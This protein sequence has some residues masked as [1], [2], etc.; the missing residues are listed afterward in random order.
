MGTTRLADTINSAQA[1]Q[2]SVRPESYARRRAL[3]WMLPALLIVVVLFGGGLVLGVLQ[4]L[5]YFPGGD[6][7]FTFN[8]VIQVFSDPDFFTSL[9]L[10]F[11]MAFTSTLI[12]T[13]LSVLCALLLTNLTQRFQWLY[14][15]LQI[16]LVVPH[17]VIAIAL[18][19]LLAPTG[20]LARVAQVFH[21]IA[22][23]EQFPLLVHDP[24]LVGVILVYV[25]KE[26][27]FITL[28]ILSVLLN[29]GPDF[30]DVGKTLKATSWQRFRFIIL[31]TIAP[32]L[33]AGALIVFAYS[34]GTF[35][36]PYLLGQTFP[37]TLPVWA[38]RNYSD[39]DLLSRPE[40]IAMGIIIAI[41]IALCVYGAHLLL[42]KPS[43]RTLPI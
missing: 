9:V 13:V 26:V 34:F 2:T 19:F 30:L 32:N 14:T 36:V 23:A 39:I 24:W 7:T 38:Y 4:A 37:M 35:E 16:P 27:P 10:T 6:A 15:I 42:R 8:H 20:F 40:G 25:W 1:I 3:L 28:M 12:A 5:G 41:I 43:S 31:P 29:L 21:V 18:L 22:D 11:Y 33:G 17:L